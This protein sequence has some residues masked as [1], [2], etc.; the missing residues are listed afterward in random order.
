MAPHD[1]DSSGDE[2]DD[3]TETNV[4]LGYASKEPED[5]SHLGGRPEWLDPDSP[6]SAALARCKVCGDLAVLLL[7]LNAELPAQFPGHERRLY[8]F[9]CRRRGCRR[10]EGSV[11]AVRGV[12][13]APGSSSSSNTAPEKKKQGR[14]R[15]EE[16][17]KPPPANLGETLFAA[18]TLGSPSSSGSANP[19]STGG[20]G[21]G[22]PFASQSAL[23]PFSNPQ[24]VAEAPTPNPEPADPPPSRG[25][26]RKEQQEQQLQS[27]PKTFAETLSLNNPQGQAQAQAPAPPEPWP[28]ESAQPRPYPVSYLTEAEYETLDPTPAPV[29]QSTVR[30]EVDN[31]SGGGKGG[32]EDRDVFESSMDA[33]FQR[34][35]DRMA[36]NPDQ[37]IRYE[38]GGQPLLYSKADAVGVLLGGGAEGGGGG[39]LAARVSGGKGMPRC[40]NCGAGRVFEVQLCPNAITELEADEMS[41]EG[42]DWGTVIVGVCERDCQAPGAGEGKAG[43]LE[44]WAG[45]QWEE[46]TSRR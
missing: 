19:F 31:D 45:V 3:Y 35:A 14:P 10:K 15:E 11:R 44:E 5:I 32:K 36:Q 25:D 29:S 22:N 16:R 8:V 23:N 42:M 30:M 28:P 7:Q 18:K 39:S 12:R 38:F 6:P 20:G 46:L 37:V 2:Q 4:L 40:R 26:A 33:T 1:S 13:I 24:A 21:G 41:L 27:L 34:F 17:L 43:Y 9:A